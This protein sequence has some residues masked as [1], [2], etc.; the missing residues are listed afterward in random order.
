MQERMARLRLSQ[1]KREEDEHMKGAA[2][3]GVF[4]SA[5]QRS[6][7]SS[8]TEMNAL[9]YTPSPVRAPV[10]IVP[11]FQSS[12]YRQHQ[13]YAVMRQDQA[14]PQ[15]H[16]PLR[17]P[18]PPARKLSIRPFNGKELYEGLGSGFLDWGRRFVRQLVLAQM[19]C[20]INWSEEVKADLLEHYLGGTAERYYHK[21]L[22]TWWQQQPTLRH[23]MERL[24]QTFRTTITQ[25]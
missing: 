21:Q 18:I 7:G 25:D 14:M 15:A 2:E 16:R 24:H 19:A 23:V 4:Q 3:T 9:L 17:A 6:F 13:E 20:G 12:M 10:P 1:L 5:F 22:E 11:H 8:R